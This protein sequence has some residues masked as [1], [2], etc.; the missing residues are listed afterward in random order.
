MWWQQI[1]PNLKLTYMSNC[2]DYLW[3]MKNNDEKIVLQKNCEPMR[4]QMKRKSSVNAE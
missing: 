1:F 4:C 3:C 2:D